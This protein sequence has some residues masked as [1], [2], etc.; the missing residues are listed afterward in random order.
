MNI[1]NIFFSNRMVRITSK[2]HNA[3]EV[4]NYFTQNQWTF[5]SDNLNKLWNRLNIEDKN[6]FNFDMSSIDWKSLAEKMHFGIRR[7]L[8]NESDDNIPKARKRMQRLAQQFFLITEF[9]QRFFFEILYRI[10]IAYL[11]FKL[12]LITFLAYLVIY[13]TP[14]CA[15]LS[16]FGRNL[17][18]ILSLIFKQFH[19]S[20]CVSSN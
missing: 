1:L 17:Y 16:F 8:L 6:E 10:I 15:F 5:K 4:M 19:K 14:I 18:N 13:W 20:G 2:M 11:I 7:H 12:V 9:N 3:M